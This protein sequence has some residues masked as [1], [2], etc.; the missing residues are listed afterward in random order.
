[1]AEEK[2]EPKPNA[3][4]CYEADLNNL[5]SNTELLQSKALSMLFTVI[6]DKNTINTD[7]VFYSDRLC[8]ILAEEGLARLCTDNMI[9]ET[10]CGKWKG[11]KPPNPKNICAVSI[12]RSGDILLEA[13]RQIC[14]GI[15]VGKILMQRDES[16]KDKN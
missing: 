1:M 11:L 7:Y 15:A 8:R 13:V 5:P 3:D 6:R 2:T 4:G 12:V 9:I 16:T 10:P 14:P